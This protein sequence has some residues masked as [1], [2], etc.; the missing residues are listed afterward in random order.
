MQAKAPIALAEYFKIRRISGAS[1]NYDES[2]LAY[3]S[4]EGGRLD[5]W[6]RP[7]AGGPAKQ[8]THVKGLIESF[9]FSPQSDLLVFAADIGGDELMQLYFTDST[10]KVPVALF[11][12]DP[13]TARSDF[14]RW[15]DDGKTL[16][17]TSNRREA[18]A[19]DL[20]EYHLLDK[21]SELLWKGSG[22]LAFV[23]PSRDHNRFLFT[24]ELSD[25]NTNLYLLDRS[26]KTPTLLTPHR[27]EA[28]FTATDLSP[29]GK[30]L[31]YTSDETGEFTALYAMEL[32][33]RKSKLVMS[34][35]WDVYNAR[36][37][38]AGKYF[39]TSVNKD[40]APDFA[41]TDVRTR[42]PVTLP[43]VKEGG[44]LIS[45]VF[46]KSDRWLAA[47]LESDYAPRSLCLIDL[48]AGT[49]RRLFD[50]S[51]ESLKRV[52]FAPAKSIRVRSFDGRDVPAFL[53]T[54][55]GVG[56]FPAMLDIHGGPTAQSA[57]T[58]R[59]F[60]QYLVSK[61][62]VVLVPNVRGSV[63]Y[64][65]TYTSLDNKDFGGG[66]LK[67]VLACKAWLVANAH[68]DAQRVAIMGQ[69]YGG[70]MTL[71]AATFTPKEFAA[72]VD[73]FGIVGLKSLVESFPTYW[74]SS[75]TYLYQKFGNPND[76]K[77]A[78]YQHE[79]SP[80]YFADRIERPLLVIQG[81]NDARVK[82]DQSDR[83]VEAVRHNGVPVE[84]LVIEGE[85]HG[86]SRTENNLRALEAADR[87][88]DKHVFGALGA[89]QNLY[90]GEASGLNRRR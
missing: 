85:G 22:Q 2:L 27:G 88:L 84:Y 75:A 87:F 47:R 90:A 24:E 82:K 60:T 54:P 59:P 17:Y 43:A 58:F 45:C 56:P 34:L 80:L 77:D 64:G 62:Y 52:R 78:Q 12:D 89:R 6:A 63:G 25:A 35:P 40:G 16:L 51:P 13:K 7:V 14:V 76:P 61:G 86:F 28:T 23:M 39:Y 57:R 50:P 46:S 41:F 8:L 44:Y 18:R 10:G 73:L 67:D 74:A 20:Y 81:A 32:A 33:T 37:S 55:A 69:S 42:K 21:R 38:R 4:D 11:P 31:Y 5:I 79:R 53:Y 1:F 48:K 3:A 26:G 30:T 19:M 65:K 70:Y 49:T 9:E 36:Y 15:A 71:A 66:P 29:D 83:L 72:H 68:V